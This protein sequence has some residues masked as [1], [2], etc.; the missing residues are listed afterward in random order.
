MKEK[1]FDKMKEYGWQLD[2]WEKVYDKHYENIN[3][4]YD[5]I[6]EENYNFLMQDISKSNFESF[7]DFMSDFLRAIN[8]IDTN[9]KNIGISGIVGNSKI[10]LYNDK[11]IPYSLGNLSYGDSGKIECDIM[12]CAFN[13]TD[14]CNLLNRE[15][16]MIYDIWSIQVDTDNLIIL[17]GKNSSYDNNI[18][19][20]KIERKEK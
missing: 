16:K 13:G 19:Y 18:V 1:I 4:W 14:L 12:N 10:S 9:N 17:K 20:L 8:D 7:V 2:N 5:F 15:D 11:H 6:V 3:E